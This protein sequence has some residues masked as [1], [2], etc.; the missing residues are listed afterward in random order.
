MTRSRTSFLLFVVALLAVFT[1]PLVAQDSTATAAPSGGPGLIGMWTLGLAA[2]TTLVTQ[3]LK[4]VATPIGN[5]PDWLKAVVAGV[6]AV[7]S[8]KLA[9]LVHAPLP[10]DLHGVAAVLVNWVAAMGI[11]AVAKKIAPGAAA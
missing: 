3:L 8:T 5:G 7:G 9:R 2:C 4:K 6:V 1:L 10:G 11:H